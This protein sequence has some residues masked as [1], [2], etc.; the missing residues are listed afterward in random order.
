MFRHQFFTAKT[1][2]NEKTRTIMLGSILLRGSWN[3]CAAFFYMHGHAAAQLRGNIAQNT[4]RITVHNN[5]AH[6][7][8][9]LL[10]RRKLK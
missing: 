3:C 1:Q 4:N 10:K 8:F 5:E 7:P 6:C 2:I 9:V